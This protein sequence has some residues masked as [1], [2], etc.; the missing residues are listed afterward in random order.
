MH[1]GCQ[2]CGRAATVSNIELSNIEHCETEKLI[3]SNCYETYYSPKAIRDQKIN[4][5]LKKSLLQRFKNLFSK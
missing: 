2:K 5:V 3:C 4:K 1:G